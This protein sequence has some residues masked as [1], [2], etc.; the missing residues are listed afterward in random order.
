MEKSGSDRWL[1]LRKGKGTY[2]LVLYK[3]GY[4]TLAKRIELD[5]GGVLRLKDKMVPGEAKSPEQLF[6]Q[7]RPK[8]QSTTRS[9]DRRTPG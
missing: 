8:E 7:V 3:E 5:S 9:A 6:A 1:L 4:E 2:H